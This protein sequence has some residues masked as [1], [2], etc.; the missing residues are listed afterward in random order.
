MEILF[1]G[2]VYQ[3]NYIYQYNINSNIYFDIYI[4]QL[5]KHTLLNDIRQTT[6]QTHMMMILISK[7]NKFYAHI[8]KILIIRISM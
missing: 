6:T 7:I 1:M 8:N 5:H 3:Q 4:S 2:F